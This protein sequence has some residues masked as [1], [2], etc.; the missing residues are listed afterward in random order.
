MLFKVSNGKTDVTFVTAKEV[1]LP[2]IYFTTD[3]LMKMK[4]YVD[5]HDKE[6]SWLGV[7]EKEDNT[8]TVTDVML[9]KQKVSGVTTDI[10]EES[11]TEFGTKLIAEGKTD[12]FN[13]IRLWG[14]SHVNM[15]VFASGTDNETFEQ[16]YPHCDYFI[17]L[18]VNKRG[19]ITVDFVDM[20]NN[21]KFENIPWEELKTSEQVYI[22]ELMA[23]FN[24]DYTKK[25]DEIK[26]KAKEE[27]KENIINV[28]PG[29]AKTPFV[30]HAEYDYDEY[31]YLN[32]SSYWYDKQKSKEEALKKN[33]TKEK[34]DERNKY[35]NIMV[36][37]YGSINKKPFF[38]NIESIF[39]EITII[40]II[41]DGMF[42]TELREFYHD[43][44]R[45]IHY[46]DDDWKVLYE[47]IEDEYMDMLYEDD[48]ITKGAEA[49]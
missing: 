39:D 4:T 33:N 1:E 12:L 40:D 15:Q 2:K 30:S 16:F 49:N 37:R 48:Y 31:T 36:K 3:V 38:V 27:I 7:V 17:R 25:F 11:L 22:E 29:E 26:A 32:D 13:K 43:D 46:S 8:Y 6:I 19:D 14:H 10:S 18:I 41:D 21:L 20:P 23:E 47:T 42:W 45:F 35:H 44:P 5:E 24:K 28:L 34:D 9:F